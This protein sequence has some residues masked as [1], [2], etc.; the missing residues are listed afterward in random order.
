MKYICSIRYVSML[1]YPATGYWRLIK[2]KFVYDWLM[3]LQG[4]KGRQSGLCRR[5]VY[6]QRM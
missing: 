4:V 2:L 1:M 3:W 6:D 5:E